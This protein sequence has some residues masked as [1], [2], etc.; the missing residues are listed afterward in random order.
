MISFRKILPFNG[1]ELSPSERLELKISYMLKIVVIATIFF[2][3]FE[4]DWFLI[5]SSITIL[6][7]SALPSLVERQFHITLPVEVDLVLTTFIF[8]HFILGEFGQYYL[9]FWW[10]DLLLHGSS[11]IIIGMVGFVIIYFFLYTR[12]IQANPLLVT[13]FSVS[14]SLAAGALWE[15]FEFIMDIS[16]GMNMQKSGLVDTMTDLI[17]DFIGAGLVGIWVYR[18][19]RKDEDGIIKILANR[20]IRFNL[21]KKQYAFRTSHKSDGDLHN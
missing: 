2:S 10:F 5:A 11:G 3:L 7:F 15:I 14:F 13:V 16:F 19:L 9:K 18:Y 12:K 4:K 1:I 21:R 8:F 20:F 6:F 17:I